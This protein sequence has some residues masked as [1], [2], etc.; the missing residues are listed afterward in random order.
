MT[1]AA[2]AMGV[3]FGILIANV[4]RD[5]IRDNEKR[6][7]KQEAIEHRRDNERHLRYE[8]KLED[9]NEHLWNSNNYL[10]AV[11]QKRKTLEGVRKCT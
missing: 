1:I 8:M 10:R 11:N 9:L 5:E 2:F 7:R 3:I 4:C 6:L